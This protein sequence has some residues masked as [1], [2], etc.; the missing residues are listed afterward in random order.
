MSRNKGVS[1][2]ASNFE[3]LK[4]A[5]LDSRSLVEAY[6]DLIKEETWQNSVDSN[7]YV[8]VGM[9]V[10][11]KDKPGQIFQLI[12]EDYTQESS[13]KQIS[14]E[15][16]TVNNHISNVENPHKVTKEQ[17]G[18]SNVDNTSDE[19]KPISTATQAALS[20]K[21]DKE[22]G[23]GLSTEDFTTAL[24]ELLEGIPNTVAA[25]Y[26]KP[27]TGIPK[28]DLTSD[29]QDSL[30][31]A[32]SAIQDISSKL[33]V[34]TYSTDKVTFALKTEIPTTLPASDVSAWAKAVTKPTYTAAEVGLD[35]VDNTADKDK[36]ISTATQTVLDAKVDKISGKSLSTNDYTTAEKNKLAGIDENANNYSL[37]TATS[38]ILGGVKSLTTGTTTGRNY[39]VEVNSDGTMKVNVPWVNTTYNEATTTNNGL[40]SSTDKSKL[41]GIAEGANKYTHPSYTAAA[42][43][44]Y[45]VTVDGAGHVSGTTAVGKTDITALGIPSQDTTYSNAT[46]SSAG[47]MSKDDKSKLDGIATNANNYA[48]PTASSN[49]L[50]GIKVGTNL[51][52]SNGVLSS[53]DTTYSVAST[54]AN[55]LMSSTDKSKLDGI[56]TGANNYSLPTA[57]SSTLGGVKI[58]DNI[59]INSGTISV[60]VDSSLSDTSTNPVQNKVI[61]NSINSI[62]SSI[63]SI[64]STIAEMSCVYGVRHYYNNSSTTLTRIGSNNL[65]V[66]L[67]VQSRMRRCVLADDGSVVYYLDANDSTKKE[68]GTDAVLDGTDGQVMVEVPE[69]YRRHTLG[70]DYYDSEIALVPFTGAF[71]VNKYYVSMSE[72][73]MDRT[74]NKLSSVVNTTT[75]YRGGN[76]TSSW[77]DT[78]R[79]LLGMPATNINTINF[80]TYANNRG[81]GWEM[82]EIDIHDDIYWLYV[83]EYAN[84]NVQLAYNS[85]LTSEGYH[86][87]GLGDGVIGKDWSTWSSYNS[88]NPVIPCGATLS[89]G[90]NSGVVSYSPL[91]SDGSTAWGTFSVPSYRGIQNPYAHIWQWAIGYMGVGNGTNQVAY[92]CRNRNHYSV[93]SL[94]NYYSQVGLIS[95]SSG[96]TKTIV[97]NKYGDIIPTS[98]GAGDTTYFS[99]YLYE[100]HNNGSIYAA[101][102][103][104]Y[105]GL[106]SRCGFGCLALH[107]GFGVSASN[108]GSRLCFCEKNQI[109]EDL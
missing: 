52:I 38:T 44:L 77:D 56:A 65:H 60:T 45:K 20:T 27:S 64:S 98:V 40:M 13:W 1:N 57:S 4:D 62:N 30:N 51:T 33:D 25:K 16:S 8:Y 42:S 103:G 22:D 105:L 46:T 21:V 102:V 55:G 87:G 80:H 58:G 81:T 29:V 94:N 12:A 82:Y 53:K 28:T 88:N 10:V 89:L 3:V 97:K 95:S 31:K 90:N 36:P 68:D 76:N 15:N 26:T 43:G 71:K 84:T 91:S 69:H 106:G 35:K 61:N 23:K 70:S 41:N 59:N 37:P 93:G 73:A 2:Y 79:S 72:A 67:P 85:E 86:Q 107:I 5:P 11:C 9:L 47:L 108:Y 96:W 109:L 74:N 50:G 34:S 19:D 100:A 92:R 24:K 104:G 18:L 49:T 75:Q 14:G 54:T 83:I 6:A 32:D 66:T 101:L 63:S 7:K 39:N 48:L 99:D 17:L 78:Y